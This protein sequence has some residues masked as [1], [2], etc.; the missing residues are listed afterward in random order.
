M[1][2]TQ[3]VSRA[4]I[5]IELQ[6]AASVKAALGEFTQ[7]GNTDRLRV[8]TGSERLVSRE[9]FSMHDF[10]AEI[11]DIE[12]SLTYLAATAHNLLFLSGETKLLDGNKGGGRLL[13]LPRD[14][15]R[16]A[17]LTS[18]L[19]TI[20]SG[21]A[22]HVFDEF[23]YVDFSKE[24][25]VKDVARRRLAIA[26]FRTQAALPSKREGFYA[27]NARLTHHNIVVPIS[28]EAGESRAS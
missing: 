17:N 24:S 20:P 1:G 27:Q 5:R 10:Q 2:S 28:E 13:I 9:T 14:P 12:E 7:D 3:G 15:K 8:Y 4:R 18:R 6:P 11:H 22:S 16:L 23:V 26:N 19:E 21:E 25:L